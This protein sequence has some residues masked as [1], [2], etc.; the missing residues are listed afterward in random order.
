MDQR[1]PEAGIEAPPPAGRFFSGGRHSL[2]VS[3]FV[4]VVCLLGT[5]SAW[6]VTT[7]EEEERGRL[8]FHALADQIS[9]AITNR[10][11]AYEQVLK[12]GAGLYGASFSV[13][14]H[15]W[16]AY[17]AKIGIDVHYRGIRG[18]GFIK[19]VTEPRREAFLASNRVDFPANYP[20]TNFV[21][22]PPGTR[23]DY[24]VV[25]Y[26]EPI[27]GRDNARAFGFDI[28]AEPVRRA[29]AEQARDSGEATLTPP[30][31]LRQSL[32]GQPGVLL[33]QPVYLNNYPVLTVEQ[34]RTSIDGW[35]YAVFQLT[36]LM[37]NLLHDAGKDIDIEIFDGPAT[38]PGPALYNR[39]GALDA[40]R[41]E[42]PG[43]FRHTAMLPVPGREWTVHYRSLPGFA[44]RESW[45]KPLFV[46]VAGLLI[47]LLLS[48]ITRAFTTT[49]ARAEQLAQHITR[50]LRVQELAI[51]SSNSGIGILDATRPQFAFIYA[52]AAME[53]LTGYK[54]SEIQA[55]PP[56][57]LL[58]TDRDQPGVKELEL[59]VK[60][61]REGRAV[62]RCRRKDGSS[63]W[64]EVSLSPLMDR[65]GRV[66]HFVSIS[67][68]ITQR[69]EA[70]DAMQS[71]SS[72]L[73]LAT[74][75]ASLGVW[76]WDIV[77]NK[78]VWDDTMYS[79]YGVAPNK[80]S[81]AYEAWESC[82]HPEDKQRATGELQRALRGEKEFHTEFRVIW[83]DQSVH[84]IT[85]VGVVLRDPAGHPIQMLGIN[86]D[87]T[88]NRRAGHEL[89]VARRTAEA[90]NRTKSEFLANMSH[91]IRT[92]LNAIIGMTELSL[93]TPLTTEQHGFLSA[94]RQSAAELL[95]LVNDILDF[96]KIEAG[97]LE[98]NLE[99][100]F[101]R[102]ILDA[103]LLP[104]RLRAQEK[105]VTLNL[106]VDAE[107]PEVLSGDV[108]RLRQVL[109]NLVGNA[110]KFTPRGEITV[111]IRPEPGPASSPASLSL[112][113][114]VSDTGIGI[115]KEKLESIFE[116]FSQ[117][118]SSITRVY[119]G[120][121]LGLT[122][123]RQLVTLMRGRIWAESQL[124]RGSLFHFTAAFARPAKAELA[125]IHKRESP[126]TTIRKSGAHPLHILIAE[127]NRVNAELLSVLL[128]KIGHLPKVA[129]NGLEA[130]AA[131]ERSRFDLIFMDLQ[132]PGVDGYEATTR[133]R[134]RERGASRRTP[135]IA[136]TANAFQGTREHCLAAGMDDY[137]SK[138]IDRAELV[139]ALERCV[140]GAA[141]PHRPSLPVA[142]ATQSILHGLL[143]QLD[144]DTA[145]A[146]KLVELFL[147]STP[148]LLSE[149][150][151]A[152]TTGDAP[153]LRRIAH[154]LKGSVTQV[155]DP[156]A[157][158]AA[159]HL[160][161][162]AQPS[163]IASAPLAVAALESQVHRLTTEL[164]A[165]LAT[166]PAIPPAS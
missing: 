100:F 112:R 45:N 143:R 139:A 72:R 145:A 23:E 30:I 117:G 16:R 140:P 111:A 85:G 86:T 35:V 128:Q 55:M 26:L 96:A 124:G 36:D 157:R 12:G 4:L 49:R 90:A 3:L 142:P 43:A 135:I 42:A 131:L 14:R 78:L 136:V 60:G 7:A 31:Q 8:R 119:G 158:T 79:I 59:A 11:L 146:R 2:A 166:L 105:Q 13:E 149:L 141:R 160:E 69:K 144:G 106:R 39:E 1:P 121:G 88:E 123:S 122:I 5:Y 110:L 28:G 46:V 84:H 129:A 68:D 76:D 81:G 115:A 104:F 40:S 33:L 101:L 74:R 61:G 17:I 147:E 132:M 27:A 94:A 54:E 50:S 67:T 83:P 108:T 62:L 21:I 148:P 109:V 161:G 37:T 154:T 89:E 10:M 56:A 151:A 53:R 165:A 63:Y 118:D 97:R 80:F 159:L 19:Y 103:C 116:A 127:D 150:H 52:N 155:G 9:E 15:E 25:K 113:F 138:P 64:N 99:P 137:L 20:V 34:R 156:A 95:T 29:A 163:T 125:S 82:V 58:G 133:I 38:N 91:E 102:D 70:E 134:Q 77:R 47:S 153:R 48:G 120:T 130:L 18:L 114:T 73:M 93:D 75:A 87:V 57:T 66:T 41:P 152:L 98:L 164:R 44:R 6:R 22:H 65:T 92:P 71:V 107:V 24:F 51:R 32:T 126:T 162:L